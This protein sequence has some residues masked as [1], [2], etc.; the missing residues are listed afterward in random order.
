MC[1]EHRAGQPNS[2]KRDCQ[3][4]ANMGKH[5]IQQ[6]FLQIVGNCPVYHVGAETNVAEDL[7]GHFLLSPSVSL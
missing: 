2:S 4:T 1:K 6:V 7:P 3:S 5:K